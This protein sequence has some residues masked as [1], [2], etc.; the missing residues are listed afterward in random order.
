MP[1]AERHLVSPGRR[2]LPPARRR[3]QQPNGAGLDRLREVLRGAVH[4]ARGAD[5]EVVAC[6]ALRCHESLRLAAES[7]A[8]ARAMADL[9][10]GEE[11]LAAEVRV[12]LNE[13]GKVV[14]AVYTED[15]LDRIFSRFCIGK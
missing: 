12:A 15:L 4:A 3:D 7:L 11:L 6:T 8:R 14:G 2:D 5:G 9:H 13:L 1:L 10:S